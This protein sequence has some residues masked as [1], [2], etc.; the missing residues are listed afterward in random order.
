LVIGGHDPTD[1]LVNSRA[2]CVGKKQGML[3]GEPDRDRISPS[4]VERQN[5][6]RRMGILRFTRLTNGFSKKAGNLARAV[7]LHPPTTA[8]SAPKPRWKNPSPRPP[9]L[10]ARVADHVWTLEEVAAL[11]DRVGTR[12]E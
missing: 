1:R 7:R 10:V 9:A 12:R 5:L 11:L 8:S 6:T 2:T 4:Y 3:N